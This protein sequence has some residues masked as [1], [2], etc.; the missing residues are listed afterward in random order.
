ML[1]DYRLGHVSKSL[2]II[3]GRNTTLEAILG[4]YLSQVEDGNS[5]SGVSSSFSVVSQFWITEFSCVFRLVNGK[6]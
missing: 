5:L 3:H 1:D 4:I 2:Y 6:N